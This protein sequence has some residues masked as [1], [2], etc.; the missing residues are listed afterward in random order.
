MIAV[1]AD[2]FTGA[3]E[4]GGR[5][6]KHGLEVVIETNVTGKTSVDL[7]IVVSDTRSVDAQS[8]IKRIETITAKLLELKPDIIF[9]KIDS[10]LRGH[11]YAELK[12]QQRV[13]KKD[14]VLVVA[15][16]PSMMRYIK[17]GIYTIAGIELAD[18]LFAHDPE[19]PACSSNVV[20]LIGGSETQ[21]ISSPKELTDRGFFVGDVDSNLAIQNWTQQLD[22]STLFA[23]GAAFFEAILALRFKKQK[24]NKELIFSPET[25]SLYLFGSTYPKSNT[26]LNKLKQS[27]VVHYNIDEQCFLEGNLEFNLKNIAKKVAESVKQNNKVAIST[28]FTSNNSITPESIRNAMG[29]L[30]ILIFEAIKI[31][32]LYIEGG[33]TAARIISNL[34]LERLVPIN[35]L[36]SGIIQMEVEGDENLTIVTKPGSYEWPTVLMPQ[37]TIN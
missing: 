32:E 29:K 14:R 23:G 18:S 30:S 28:V 22:K 27:G 11:V 4:I 37:V 12:A 20:T 8:A 1:I 21:S 25:K 35:E 33:S 13:E 31:E 15:G 16:N 17:D 6:L 7:L 2:D 26:F 36:S 9:K 5:A 3:A 34:K 24:S 19:F 10:V